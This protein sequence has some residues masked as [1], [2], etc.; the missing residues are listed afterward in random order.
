MMIKKKTALLILAASLSS[1]SAFAG[2]D[3]KGAM[4]CGN[5]RV[6]AKYTLL[7]SAAPANGSSDRGVASY[8]IKYGNDGDSY[9]NVEV[10]PN[11]CERHGDTLTCSTEKVTAEIDLTSGH[12]DSDKMTYVAKMTV[13]MLAGMGKWDAQDGTC[14]VATSAQST[15]LE[16]LG[17]ESKMGE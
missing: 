10:T 9:R 15:Y 1:L 4:K 2:D 3:W 16:L 5:Y 11:G 7:V 12:I 17:P 8:A 13:P 14:V 6:N